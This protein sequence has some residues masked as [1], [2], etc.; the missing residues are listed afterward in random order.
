ME[1]MPKVPVDNR[2]PLLR[3][4]LVRAT[5]SFAVS[6][7]V[8]RTPLGDTLRP[9]KVDRLLYRAPVRVAV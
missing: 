4:E 6:F 1:P 5:T 7:R 9:S 2:L 8:E 3:I